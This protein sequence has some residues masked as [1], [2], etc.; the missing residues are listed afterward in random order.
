MQT[1]NKQSKEQA[2]RCYPIR[3]V[4]TT[5]QR[6]GTLDIALQYVEPLP[7]NTQSVFINCLVG[8]NTLDCKKYENKDAFPAVILEKHFTKCTTFQH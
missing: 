2:N 6:S 1:V 3:M 4:N 5:G 7:R 8:Y